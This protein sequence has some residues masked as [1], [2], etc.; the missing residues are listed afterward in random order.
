[1]ALSAEKIKGLRELYQRGEPGEKD[2]AKRI[3]EKN[4]VPLEEPKHKATFTFQ[5]FEFDSP[6]SDDFLKSIFGAEPKNKKGYG[7]TPVITG[8]A[9]E[10]QAKILNII[11]HRIFKGRKLSTS[12]DKRNSVATIDGLT[13]PELQTVK[14]VYDNNLEQLCDVALD[15]IVKAHIKM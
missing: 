2:N 1:M 9:T 11:A 5:D 7:P 12:W 8:I 14:M 10:M 3:L 13:V 15:A 4:G 6:F